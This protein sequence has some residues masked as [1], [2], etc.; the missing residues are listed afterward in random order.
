ME[1]EKRFVNTLE[2]NI[3]KR[4]AMYRSNLCSAN[5]PSD[6][7]LHLDPID[8]ENLPPQSPQI[9]KSV[10]DNAEDVRDQ[11]KPM[12][13]FDTGD[14]VGQRFLME[15]YD[16]G[17]R[18]CA[19]IIEVLDDQET[20]NVAVGSMCH[21]IERTDRQGSYPNCLDYPN[22]CHTTVTFS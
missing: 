21:I 12:I 13:Y 1:T 11:V 10:Q 22:R 9:V 20:K 5:N 18:C 3:R 6:P 19:H 15:E 8:G 4:G 16:D 17:L 7:N 2:D 14:L